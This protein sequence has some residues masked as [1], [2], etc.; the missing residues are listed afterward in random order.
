MD[1]TDG[2]RPWREETTRSGKRPNILSG[3]SSLVYAGK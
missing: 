3:T 2:R 1:L